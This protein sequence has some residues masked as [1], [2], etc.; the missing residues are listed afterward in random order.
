MAINYLSVVL[1][2]QIILLMGSYVKIKI[3]TLYI[4]HK[5]FQFGGGVFVIF[6]YERM[7]L[8]RE[9][10]GL[11]QC[12]MAVILNLT[13]QQAYQRYEAGRALMPIWLFIKLAQFFDVSVDYICCLTEDRRKYW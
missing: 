12:D 3:Q 8:L 9:E 4:F 1:L 6:Y 5:N 11:R 7:K 2:L 10:R 13:N